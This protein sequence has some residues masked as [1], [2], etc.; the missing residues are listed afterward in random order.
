MIL[1]RH[2]V[3][4]RGDMACRRRATTTLAGW[5]RAR[6]VR[7]SSVT[8]AEG[9]TEAVTA[10]RASRGV[11]GR[12]WASNERASS[13][14][15]SSSSSKRAREENEG[16]NPLSSIMFP[17]ERAVLNSE[18]WVGELKP[19]Q[20]AYWAAFGLGCVFVVGARAKRYYEDQE[21]DEER[22]KAMESNKRALQAALE[23]RSFIASGG[24]GETDEDD[25]DDDPFDG[26]SPEEIEALVK[27][28]APTGDVY[29]GMT[30][31]E[32][33]EYEEKFRG[34]GNLTW[35]TNAA[36]GTRP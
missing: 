29:E 13:S 18:R 10:A 21:T 15:S 11:G 22:Q 24:G 32:I 33:N 16:D 34:K 12:R 1:G 5:M 9:V 4:P 8:V 31:E 17:W 27:K 19:W 6:A 20:K 14:S 35:R 28:Q 26:L 36:A 23:G 2:C 3:T 25:E 7:E 30:P